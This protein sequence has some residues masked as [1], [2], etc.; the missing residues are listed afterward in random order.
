M[1]AVTEDRKVA[2]PERRRE[3]EVSDRLR[4]IEGQIAGIRRMY[5]DHRYCVDVLD[6]LSAA[7]RGLQGAAQIVLEDHVNGCVADALS[8][9]DAEEKTAELLEAVR[10]YVRSA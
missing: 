6:Q 4:R 3:K 5:E 1:D 7:R 9:G 8:G 10:R 2:R